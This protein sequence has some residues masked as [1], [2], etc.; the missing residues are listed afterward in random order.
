MGKKKTK[1]TRTPLTKDWGFEDAIL[2]PA[3]KNHTLGSQCGMCIM[4]PVPCEGT[5][6]R[7]ETWR[8]IP[9]WAGSK[10]ARAVCVTAWIAI[11]ACP[12]HLCLVSIRVS[13]THLIQAVAGA[14]PPSS[15]AHTVTPSLWQGHNGHRRLKF[16][17]SCR[18]S[19]LRDITL[20]WCF[21]FSRSKL[22][23]PVPWPLLKSSVLSYSLSILHWS[24]SNK[25]NE[26]NSLAL[27]TSQRVF[28]CYGSIFGPPAFTKRIFFLVWNLAG[29]IKTKCSIL[30]KVQCVVL[31]LTALIK[32]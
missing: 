24:Y 18:Y 23:I 19:R 30:C 17:L 4:V 1:Q 14:A 27:C 10:T 20:L 7:A 11:T 26:T 16:L 21:P 9:L 8:P 2:K 6:G 31:V 15:F 32:I 22:C 29:V 13:E 25:L 5:Q 28:Y 12:N 3:L